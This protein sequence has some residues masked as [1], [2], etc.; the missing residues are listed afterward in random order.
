MCQLSFMGA[1]IGH[2]REFAAAEAAECRSMGQTA[3]KQFREFDKG[4]EQPDQQAQ[5]VGGN[6]CQLPPIAGADGF[7]DDFGEDQDQQGQHRRGNADIGITEYHRGLGSGAGGSHRMGDG[8]EGQ[9]RGQGPAHFGFLPAQDRSGGLLRL[10]HQNDMRHGYA[11]QHRFGDGA[12]KG[13]DQ[14]DQNIANKQ[15]HSGWTRTF[16]PGRGIVRSEICARDKKKL[17]SGAIDLLSSELSG[18]GCPV[19]NTLNIAAC[20]G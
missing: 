10:L 3:G 18:T 13:E 20:D 7:R 17:L 6:R 19:M 5:A 14:R 11:E 12:E 16:R 1:E 8:I 4:V 9:N 2:G 15:Q